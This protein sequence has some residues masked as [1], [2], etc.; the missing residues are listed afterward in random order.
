MEDD[1]D[2]PTPTPGGETP[3]QQGG[4]SDAGGGTDDGGG[5][6]SARLRA[7]E[8][9]AKRAEKERDALKRQEEE[10]ENAKLS[11]IERRDKKIAQLEGQVTD[12]SG[13]LTNTR[14]RHT[15]DQL[16]RDAGCRDCDLAFM[17]ADLSAVEI[18]D[19]KA[20]GLDAVLETLKT[21][22]PLLFEEPKPADF[23]GGGKVTDAPVK[24][25][26]QAQLAALSPEEFAQVVEDKKAGRVSIL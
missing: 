10:R 22:K 12:L 20:Q 6:I 4:E 23:G 26:N 11:E 25:Y 3:P 17:A 24:T 15:F 14:T 5:N 8:S 2:Q 16:A 1:N 9:R 21:S 19:G 7:A 13:E 18:V